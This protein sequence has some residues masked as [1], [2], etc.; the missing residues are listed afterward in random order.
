MKD[1]NENNENQ[2]TGAGIIVFYD[3]RGV[4]QEYVKGLKKDVLY[5]FL[6][7]LDGK[8]DFPK[9]QIDYGE[10]CLSCAI[11][12]TEEEISLREKDYFLLDKEG[13]DFVSEKRNKKGEKH[14]LKMYIAEL[15]RD[16]LGQPALKMNPKTKIV[17]HNS[18]TFAPRREYEKKLLDYLVPTIEW[19]DNIVLNYLKG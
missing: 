7:G 12:E 2:C 9:G 11:R 6:E 18:F 3:N 1:F 5:L 16:S 10:Y 17:E 8:Y 13:K 14:V 15:K 4:K 19:A